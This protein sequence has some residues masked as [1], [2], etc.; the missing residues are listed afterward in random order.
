MK[1]RLT[2]V[3]PLSVS[4]DHVGPLARTVADAWA[5]FSAL[6]GVAPPPR[7]AVT[8]RTACDSAQLGGY[9]LEKLDAEVRQPVR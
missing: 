7:R 1:F 5:V 8:S 6:A 3:V 2:G 4:L 9:F